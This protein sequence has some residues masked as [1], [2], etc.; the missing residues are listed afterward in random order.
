MEDLK[1]ILNT[2]PFFDGLNPQY[3]QLIVGCASNVRF[4]AGNYIFREGDE[5]DI[6]YLVREGRVALETFAPNQ[7]PMVLQIVGQGEVLGWSWLVPP[8]RW[9]N[10]ARAVQPV[11]AIALDG[12]CLRSK[13]E[14]DNKLGYE[15]LKRVVHVIGTRLG[16]ARVNML[17]VYSATPVVLQQDE[18]EFQ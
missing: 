3:F 14:S 18:Q 7:K 8:Y 5:A 1:S 17:D 15:L 10:S 2:H 11:R 4:E 12:K 6:F 13:C 16:T 9:S